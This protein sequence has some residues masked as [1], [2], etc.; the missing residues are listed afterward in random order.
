MKRTLLPLALVLLS[1]SS[2]LFSQPAQNTNQGADLDALAAT[3]RTELEA[4]GDRVLGQ[5]AYRWSTR[6]E[7]ISN[8]RA[9]FSV[10]VSNNVGQNTVRT[11]VRTE[12][13]ELSLGALDRIG[14]SPQK[15]WLE[16]PCLNKANCIASSTAC[17]QKSKDG[18]VTDCST[19]SQK[20]VDTFRLEL[21]SEAA[22]SRMQK[23][24]SSAIDI[25]RAPAGVA[26]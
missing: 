5:D 6:L 2:L 8:C 12:Y 14:V 25:C 4:H 15:S 26:F 9:E 3:I 19:A 22:I 1:F 21:D 16:I 13:V 11:E 23:V 20:R 7:G 18:I 17:V 24:F 10:R